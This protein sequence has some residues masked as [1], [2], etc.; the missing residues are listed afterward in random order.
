MNA[1]LIITIAPIF[2]LAA[3]KLIEIILAGNICIADIICSF[4][5]GFYPLNSW[6]YEEFFEAAFYVIMINL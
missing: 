2:P 3:N 6:I 1:I 5:I 4:Q